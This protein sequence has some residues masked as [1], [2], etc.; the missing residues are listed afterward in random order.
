VT[1]YNRTRDAKLPII[2]IY[3]H[4]ERVALQSGMAGQ[5]NRDGHGGGHGQSSNQNASYD[6]CVT[7][8]SPP[9]F[10]RGRPKMKL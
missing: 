3:I 6:D 2:Y 4:E 5:D 8:P 1:R 7:E 10:S 9:L